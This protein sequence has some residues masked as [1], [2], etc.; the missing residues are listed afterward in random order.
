MPIEQEP[1]RKYNLTEKIDT[2][3]IRLNPKERAYFNESKAII[4]Q[5]KDSTALK[6][7]AWIGAKVIH[8][9]KM[10]QILATVFK[11]K[12]NNTRQNIIDFEEIP[13]KSDAEN[14]EI[15]TQ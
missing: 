9:G 5:K 6:Q 13:N 3:T 7:L 2:F 1:F 8:E 15:V 14:Q 11:N 12:R 4:E 10:K